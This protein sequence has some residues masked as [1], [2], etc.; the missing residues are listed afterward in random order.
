MEYYIPTVLIGIV[1]VVMAFS[2]LGTE[3]KRRYSHFKE[4]YHTILID[5]N[6]EDRVRDLFRSHYIIG[7]RKRRCDIY[8]DDPSVSRVHA[9]LWHDG[10]HFCIAPV[11]DLEILN[12]HKRKKLPKVYVNNEEV[13]EDGV[14]LCRG[15]VIRLGNSRF[16]LEDSRMQEERR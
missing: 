7:R 3:E 13:S 10:I 16:M 4:Q 1:T 6:E 12:K 5:L 9:V 14:V 2:L 8:L 11:R 15:D